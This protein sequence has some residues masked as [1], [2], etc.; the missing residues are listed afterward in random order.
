MKYAYVLL[1]M[2]E[3]S[4]RGECGGGGADPKRHSAALS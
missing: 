3:Q 4:E 2:D 1:L